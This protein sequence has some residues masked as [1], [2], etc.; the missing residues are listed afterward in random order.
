MFKKTNRQN[1]RR[2]R[3]SSEDEQEGD[4]NGGGGGADAAAASK[5]GG[6]SAAAPA[7]KIPAKS[8]SPPPIKTASLLSFD[9]VEEGTHLFISYISYIS[10][11]F[12]ISIFVSTFLLLFAHFFYEIYAVWDRWAFLVYPCY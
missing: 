1:F 9:A 8:P 11:A 5:N 6:H 4:E 10:C 7:N 12:T 3:R 2:Q